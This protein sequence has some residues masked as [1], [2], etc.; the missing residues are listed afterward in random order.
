MCGVEAEA[1][2]IARADRK[3]PTM[4]GEEFVDEAREGGAMRY[5]WSGRSAVARR[6]RVGGQQLVLGGGDRSRRLD[7]ERTL[8]PGSA[9][10]RIYGRSDR[11][12]G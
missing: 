1:G 12:R 5:L 9:V 7:W 6:T 11:G 2:S 10:A 3:S 8:I 4:S